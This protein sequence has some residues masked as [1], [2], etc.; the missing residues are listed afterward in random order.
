MSENR[1]GHS[2][3][4]PAFLGVLLTEKLSVMRTRKNGSNRHHHKNTTTK[5]SPYSMMFRKNMD[6]CRVVVFFVN[7]F[8]RLLYP[9]LS[10]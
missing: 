10:V 3:A 9:S 8:M 5:H 1:L 7:L 4:M 2:M 6:C